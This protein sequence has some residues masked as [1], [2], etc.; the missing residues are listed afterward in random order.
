MKWAVIAEFPCVSTKG[1]NRRV[2]LLVHNNDNRNGFIIGPTA[3]L[4]LVN[5]GVRKEQPLKYRFLEKMHN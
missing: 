1:A 4:N 5:Q 2:Y 3:K